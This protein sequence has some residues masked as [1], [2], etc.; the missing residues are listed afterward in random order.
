MRYKNGAKRFFEE[1]DIVKILRSNRLS[2]IVFKST[3]EPE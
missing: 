3:L 1:M 2:K